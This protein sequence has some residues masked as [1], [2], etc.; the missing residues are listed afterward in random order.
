MPDEGT[1]FYVSP[2]GDD[3][4]SGRFAEPDADAS[5]GPFRTPA[6]ARDA[7]RALERPLAGPVTVRL[8][9][10]T[11]GLDEPLV[12][13]P[14]DSGA[15]KAPVTWTAYPGETPVLSGGRPVTG[16][17]PG[18]GG[19]WIADVPDARDRAWPFRQLFV[20]GE[21]RPRPS[22][23]KTGTY[24]IAALHGLDRTGKPWQNPMDRFTFA[25]GNLRADWTHLTDVEV[26]VLHFWVDVHLPVKHIDPDRR[27][28]LFDRQSRRRLTDDFGDAGARYRVENVLEA[29]Q[30]PGEWYLDAAA[31][32][33]TY[34]PKPGEQ[35]G[36][37]P[38]VAPR[39]EC[40][41]RF[42]GRPDQD[43]DVHDVVLRGL[44]FRHNRAVL[45]PDNA[46]DLQAAVCIP[47]ALRMRYASRC[48][49]EQCT[50]EHLGTYAVEIQQGCRDV[51]IV[52][53]TMRDLGA[54]GVKLSGGDAQS[55]Q[56]HR[57]LRCAVT[58]N[59]IHDAGRIWHAAV[60]VLLRHAAH[61]TV[62]HNHIHHL[63]YTGVSVG[64]VWGYKPSVAV[65]NR[66]TDNHIHHIG[67]GLLSDIGGVYTLG[68]SP[69]TVVARNLIH[70]VRSYGYGGW[71]IYTDEGSSDILIENN[72][73]YRTKTGGFHQHYGRDNVVRNNV[74][75]FAAEHQ[76]QRSRAEPHSSFTFERNI[77]Y[78]KTGPLLGKTWKDGRFRMDSNL[79]WNAAGRPVGFAGLTLDAW[80]KRGHD[81]HSR[82]A[83]PRF[84][85][86]DQGDFRL[87]DD[88]P[89]FGLGFRP[90][91]LSDVGPRPDPLPA[92]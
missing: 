79:Y 33:I 54:G 10:G 58:D 86:P 3:R 42:E 56:R 40:L 84:L 29:L 45:P 91:D 81:V 34:L 63:Y 92:P 64:W 2:D 88:S 87:R 71:G 55:P 76:L 24:R 51:R 16:F 31:G 37:T 57:T 90:I 36:Q 13:T 48:A 49:V 32:R 75:A 4:F 61:C 39:L 65:A 1:V 17:Q 35:I 11:Y 72:V 41:V 60:G 80:Q 21:R 7:V 44:V 82:V 66:I 12:F 6:R 78:W 30:V 70:D 74:F 69:G 23:P 27:L 53:N 68:P 5:D 20:G 43:A 50:F 73:V 25:P 28:V 77:V 83:D 62:A 67:Q 38:V 52:S 9:G 15:D 19:R 14:E 18:P 89:A 8:R 26:V 47:G 46:A 22:L 59:H 85:D